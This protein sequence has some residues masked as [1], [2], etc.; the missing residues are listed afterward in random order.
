MLTTTAAVVAFSVVLARTE[1][2]TPNDLATTEA[3]VVYY[4]GGKHEI[5][6][7]SDANRRASDLEQIPLHVQEAVLAAEDRGFYD[8]GGI[9][10]ISIARAAVNLSLIHISAPTRPY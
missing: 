3:T 7:L 2:P 6:R 10:P 8:H 9:S 1:V 4:A 5:G